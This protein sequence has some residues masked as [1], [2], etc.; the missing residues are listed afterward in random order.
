MDRE[1]LVFERGSRTAFQRWWWT[2]IPG[3]IGGLL[4][5]ALWLSGLSPAPPIAP[6]K[7]A[8]A[9]EVT[10][11]RSTVCRAMVSQLEQDFRRDAVRLELLEDGTVSSTLDPDAEDPGQRALR[12]VMEV[13]IE[14]RRRHDLDL[15][16]WEAAEGEATV[17]R[18]LSLL[19]LSLG[20]ALSGLLLWLSRRLRP[21]RHQIEISARELVIDGQ[22]IRMSDLA[23]CTLWPD[24]NGVRL[25]EIEPDVGPMIRLY[26]P[27]L[28]YETD[29]LERLLV[30]V[31]P[32]EAERA[33]ERRREGQLKR[34][35]TQLLDR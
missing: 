7:A 20:G 15:A 25:L 9:T 8:C 14:V 2:A 29:R 5:L 28:T 17:V 23:D 32:S 6:P 30:Q 13:G 12:E 11:R 22:R 3:V 16:R 4:A 33:A 26:L 31:V 19:P 24:K 18:W 27:T 1:T 35:A 34:E 21:A 10:L